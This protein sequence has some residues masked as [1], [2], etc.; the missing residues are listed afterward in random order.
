MNSSGKVYSLGVPVSILYTFLLLRGISKMN[1][2]SFDYH[3]KHVLRW[4]RTNR[5]Y[6]L[7]A[8][9]VRMSQFPQGAER[10]DKF[11]GWG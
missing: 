11:E 4:L 10:K 8:I 2:E 7:R 5:L 6:Y 9:K 3:F 1:D